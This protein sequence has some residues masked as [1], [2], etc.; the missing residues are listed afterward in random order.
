MRSKPCFLRG[1][2][3]WALHTN[4]CPPTVKHRSSTHPRVVATGVLLCVA[5]VW[6]GGYVAHCG[7][8]MVYVCVSACPPARLCLAA[9][10]SSVVVKGCWTG[11]ATKSTDMDSDSDGG[12]DGDAQAA[13]PH[14][15]RRGCTMAGPHG[16][17]TSS[18]A[19]RHHDCVGTRYFVH[20]HAQMCLRAILVVD[21]VAK[22]E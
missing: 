14:I 11:C 17:C 9:C 19:L 10:A 21:A 20:D 6:W 1:R 22:D 2:W 12:N 18:L 5:C 13:V 7:F 15:V 4:S 8:H 3:L 16:K